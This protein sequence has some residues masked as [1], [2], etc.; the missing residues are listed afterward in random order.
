MIV[1]HL[2]FLLIIMIGRDTLGFRATSRC[3]HQSLIRLNSLGNETPLFPSGI[4]PVYKPQNWTS[5][6]VVSK[7]KW[8]ILNGLRAENRTVN[9]RSSDIKVGHGGTLDPMAEG[10]LVIGINKGTKQL[11]SFLD[12]A[13]EYRVQGKFGT[14]TDTYDSTGKVIETRDH[15]HITSLMVK[16]A[17]QSFVGEIYQIP[18]MFS[19][20]KHNG[21]RLYQYARDGV[22]IERPPRKVFVY[23]I[24]FTEDSSLL[25]DE[26]ELAVKC[27]GGFYV[28]SLVHDLGQQLNSCAHMTTLIR[29]RQGPFQLNECLDEC[30]WDINTIRKSIICTDLVQ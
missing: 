14:S 28:R 22:Q 12:G 24:D 3:F 15:M 5:N 17:L 16:G 30:R 10:V 18:P 11:K 29:T 23:G 21:K 2:V 26:F 1:Q 13:K 19:A 9:I 7:I 20:L 6:D 4:I 27:G 25:P 8:V